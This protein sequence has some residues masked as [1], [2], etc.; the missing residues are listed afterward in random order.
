MALA[1]LCLTLA[2]CASTGSSMALA[3]QPVCAAVVV[4]PA[5]P[6]LALLAGRELRR[7]LWHATGAL[8]PIHRATS[9]AP[10]GC[11]RVVVAEAPEQ[12]GS[13]DVDGATTRGSP[14]CSR[15]ST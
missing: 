7:Y 5:A 13:V 10:P 2:L 3:P 4:D 9:A 12:L 14:R 11:W 6:A 8:A 15:P 1:L